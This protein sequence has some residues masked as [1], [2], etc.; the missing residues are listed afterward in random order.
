MASTPPVSTT[1]P[2]GFPL[3]PTLPTVSATTPSPVANT[4][5]TTPPVSTWS[6][7]AATA[8]IAKEYSSFGG[9]LPELFNDP[10]STYAKA[11]DW[12]LDPTKDL[13][14]VTEPAAFLQ[15]YT[16]VHFYYATTSSGAWLSCN[17]PVFELGET[18]TCIFQQLVNEHPKSYFAIP[19]KRWLSD[20]HECS[21]AGIVC[22]DSMSVTEIALGTSSFPSFA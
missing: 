9:F 20:V 12:V 11:L 18:A 1:I 5:V 19:S 2:G 7:E 8:L 22:D 14:Q 15:R 16:L 4:I 21:W 3:P 13:L 17:P 6:R 10:T